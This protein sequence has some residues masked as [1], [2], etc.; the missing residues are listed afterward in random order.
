MKLK[1]DFFS[2]FLSLSLSLSLSECVFLF[3]LWCRISIFLKS[4]NNNKN[5]INNQNKLLLCIYRILQFTPIESLVIEFKWRGLFLE[6]VCVCFGY[7]FIINIKLGVCNFLLFFLNF[8]LIECIKWN[9][10]MK[11]I[12]ELC[13]IVY[14]LR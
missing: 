5:D 2:D 1:S 8:F 11:T 10:W 6:S 3:R 14:R 7:V 13:F 4:I 12:A 9:N